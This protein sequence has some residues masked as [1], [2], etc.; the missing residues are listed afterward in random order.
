MGSCFAELCEHHCFGWSSFLF[1]SGGLRECPVYRFGLY[2]LELAL[3]RER[4]TVPQSGLIDFLT[5]FSDDRLLRRHKVV[6]SVIVRLGDVGLIFDT[7]TRDVRWLLIVVALEFAFQAFSIQVHRVDVIVEL[8]ENFAKLYPNLEVE[9][10]DV[11]RF[12]DLISSHED[13]LS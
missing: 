8:Q 5:G 9:T 4:L 12:A 3:T 2:G 13:M 6:D 10:H 11:L 7:A 1:L